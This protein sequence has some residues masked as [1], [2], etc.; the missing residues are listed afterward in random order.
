M[1]SRTLRRRRIGAAIAM[2]ILAVV[3]MVQNDDMWQMQSLSAPSPKTSDSVS[4][5]A[6]NLLTTIPIKGRAPKTGYSRM[7][8][9]DGWATTDGCDTRNIILHR[10]LQKPV[11]GDNC[12]VLSGTLDDPYTGKTIVFKRGA[13]SSADV[14]IDH[15]VA[16]GDTWQKGAQQLSKDER[17]RLANDPLELLAVD[18]PANQQKSDADAATWLPSNKPFRCQY[19]ARQIAVKAKYH[20]WMTQAEH[21]AIAGILSRC[22][23]QPLP[24]A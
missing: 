4:G 21:D 19:V 20:L 22:P 17:L 9:G 16:L 3:T 8:Y 10:D 23:G 18:G 5:D 11:V 24:M 14:Q 12:N 6:A 7:Q 1:I 15:V 13:D 2:L